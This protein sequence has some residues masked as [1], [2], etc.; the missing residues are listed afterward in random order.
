ISTAV[1]FI[2]IYIELAL[3]SSS[4]P[5]LKIKKEPLRLIED[6]EKVQFLK[7]KKTESKKIM[8]IS[9]QYLVVNLHFCGCSFFVFKLFQQPPIDAAIPLKYTYIGS[10]H[11][12]S[13]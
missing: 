5:L 6:T 11:F 1:K 10:D 7:F 13:L 3:I 4:Q 8:E 2:L 9:N 12:T